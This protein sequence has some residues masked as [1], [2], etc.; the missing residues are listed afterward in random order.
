MRHLR[1]GILL[2]GAAGFLGYHVGRYFRG[3]G[4]E[5]CGLWHEDPPDPASVH[6]AVRGDLVA[7]DAA[8]MLEDAAAD[9]VV[10]CAALSG[11][12]QCEADPARARAVNVEA[13]RRLAAAAAAR[14]SRFVFVSTDLVF[15]GARAPYREGD[16]VSPLSLYAET[17]AEAERAVLAACP[18]AWVVRTALMYGAGP[19]GGAG[20][21]LA[22]TL[23]ALKKG[24]PLRLYTNQIRTPLHAP[25]AAR[26]I[27]L[28]LAS[29]A[30]PGIYHAGGPDRLSRHEIGLR[31]AAAFRLS[32]AHIVPIE[33]DRPHNLGPLDDCSLD[34]TKAASLEMQFT[35]F[36][37]GIRSLAQ[38]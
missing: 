34:C 28:L 21:F 17:K 20:S 8:A 27:G 30:A 15:D 38:N 25:D 1:N 12:A 2:T 24:D 35:P 16:P 5:V 6:R 13:A 14:S 26:F 22:W 4:W 29:N 7:M 31:I 10:H 19:R 33:V 3:A 32:A 23:D 36:D 9:V 11:R 18:E 37:A